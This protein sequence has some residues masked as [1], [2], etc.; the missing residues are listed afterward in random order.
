[1]DKVIST[2]YFE[3]KKGAAKKEPRTFIR[4][5]LHCATFTQSPE[6]GFNSLQQT[7]NN[8]EYKQTNIIFKN[9]KKILKYF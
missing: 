5:Q 8:T 4:L 1:L 6:I 2:D 9:F 7:L 3:I